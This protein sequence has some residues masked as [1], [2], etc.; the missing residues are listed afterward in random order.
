MRKIIK[1]SLFGASGLF[2]A[3]VFISSLLFIYESRKKIQNFILLRIYDKYIAKDNA[4]G[5]RYLVNPLKISKRQI[6]PKDIK[7]LKISEDADISG[8]WLSRAMENA[9]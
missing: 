2:V 3:V 4:H 6:P 1:Y 5:P 7:D 8:Q 9:I